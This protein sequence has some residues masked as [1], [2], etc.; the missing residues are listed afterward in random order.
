MIATVIGI[1]NAFWAAMPI[2]VV[3]QATRGLTLE[4][5]IYRVLGTLVGAIAGFGILQFID[6]P[7]ISP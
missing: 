2:F 6:T 5:G 3:A 4:R 1:Y 7:S